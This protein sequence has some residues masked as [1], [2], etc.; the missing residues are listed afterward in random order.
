MVRVGSSELR[1]IVRQ[2]IHD[3]DA[4]R[5]R[6]ACTKGRDCVSSI[7]RMSTWMSGAVIGTASV[8]VG[9]ISPSTLPGSMTRTQPSWKEKTWM[10]K[11]PIQNPGNETMRDGRPRKK[12]AIPPIPGNVAK[13]ATST[14]TMMAK[15]MAQAA[16]MRVW[17]RASASSVATG[18]P[19]CV[20]LP[21]WPVRKPPNAVKYC[22]MSGLSAPISSRIASISAWDRP[23]AGSPKRDCTASD[24]SAERRKKATV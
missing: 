1:R 20:E 2:K 12:V 13:K 3:S 21:K 11:I 19:D 9:K 17:G 24:G 18:A 7:E 15:P 14:A 10:S 5:E 23:K 16:R 22:T 6:T 8:S 4:P